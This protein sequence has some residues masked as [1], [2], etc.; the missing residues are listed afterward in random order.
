[1]SPT[2]Q[3]FTEAQQRRY[4]AEAAQR[5]GTTTVD[6]AAARWNACTP[7][8]QEQIL[9]EG[10][11]IYRDLVAAMPT[12]VDSV[13]TLAILARW[14][15]HLRAFY[16]PTFEVLAGLGYTYGHDPEFRATFAAFHP[17]LPDFIS[18]AVAVYVD[19]LETAWLE[20]ELHILEE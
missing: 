9:A 20:Q 16:E 19:A 1:M 18:S 2:D 8:Q 14:H 12:G 15:Q 4:A 11:Q 3:P 7:E 6:A 13:A 10:R 5:Y 17:D